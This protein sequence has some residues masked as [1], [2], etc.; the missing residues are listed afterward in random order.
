[1]RQENKMA[2]DFTTV[3]NR[4]GTGSGKW[5]EMK[6]YGIADASVT[7]MSTAEMEFDNAPEIKR[8]LA[9]YALG[10]VLSYYDPQ[11]AYFEAVANWLRDRQGFLVDREAIIPN[12]SLHAALA[13]AVMAFSGPDDAVLVPHPV[14]PCF[15][16]TVRRL[17]R[18]E[19]VHE[20]VE[21]DLLYAFDFDQ[22]DRDLAD[23]A[24]K[25][26]LLCS[27][28]NPVGRSWTRRELETIAALCARHGVTIVSDEIHADLTLPGFTH[29]PIATVS[30]DTAA[31]TV[32]FTSASKAFNL[33]GLD[34]ANVII[35]NAGLR[36]RYL[37]ARR[38]EGLSS[39]N[40]LGLKACELAYT[41]GAT[42]LDQCRATIAGNAKFIAKFLAEN[43]PGIKCSPLEA[44]YLLWVDFRSLGLDGPAL[45]RELVD[46][47]RIFAGG[48]HHFGHGGEGF[49]RINIACPLS[50]VE[51][52]FGRI[53]GWVR[54]LRQ[55]GAAKC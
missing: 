23:P 19:I 6:A 46:K 24:C 49:V 37:E 14:W 12:N 30:P 15:I 44:T 29:V 8:G 55:Q 45:E 41:K 17:G 22:L 13:T 38:R 2:Y 16:S 51:D 50:T 21:K 7:P 27:P 39:P 32:T 9:D 35:P 31:R 25:L 3:L 28:H 53:A 48:G 47:A 5:E 1:M 34:S 36:A 10:A 43:T 11:P 40:M 33:A 18:R 26:M 42:W 4:F 20:L 54:A 52:A